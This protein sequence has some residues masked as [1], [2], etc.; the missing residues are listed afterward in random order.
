MERLALEAQQQGLLDSS[1][2]ETSKVDKPNKPKKFIKSNNTSLNSSAE[3]EDKKN[4]KKGQKLYCVCRT[5]Y[6]KS[7]YVIITIFAYYIQKNYPCLLDFTSAVTCVIIGFMAC[8][9]GLLRS[10]QKICLILCVPTAREPRKRRNFSA[11]AVLR[12]TNHSEFA[13]STNNELA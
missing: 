11:Y 4:K 8:A 6:D 3:K 13:Q 10:S 5:P 9:L 2:A 12:T 7:K 1:S